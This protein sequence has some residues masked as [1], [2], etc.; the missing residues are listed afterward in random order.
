MRP[1]ILLTALV[2]MGLIDAQ[3]V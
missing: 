2:G 1:L 3:H